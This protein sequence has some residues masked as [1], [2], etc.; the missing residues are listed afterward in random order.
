MKNER[1]W[2]QRFENFE[3]AWLL[4]ES[5]VSK[6]CKSYSDLEKEGIIQRFEF[7]F[8]LAWKT[9][10]DYLE[11][12][13]VELQVVT[14]RSVIEAGFGSKIIVDGQVWIDMLE[15]RNIMSHTYNKENFEK[16]V[17][18]IFNDYSEAIRQVWSFFRD[19][20]E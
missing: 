12:N 20:K 18:W 10:R 13:G 8:E 2:R 9:I 5:A 11:Y 1:R 14:P 7:T 16:A 6:D 17:E 19:I 4:L 15:N 3:K